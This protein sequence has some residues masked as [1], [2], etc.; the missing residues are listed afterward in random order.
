MLDYFRRLLEG[1]VRRPLLFSQPEPTD[2]M[3]LTQ[4]EPPC[5]SFIIVYLYVQYIVMLLS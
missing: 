1:E 5:V 4:S 2:S 3:S